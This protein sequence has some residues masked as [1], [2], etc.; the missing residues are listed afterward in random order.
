MFFLKG[1]EGGIEKEGGN[2]VF[3]ITVVLNCNVFIIVPESH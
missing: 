1:G 2:H 3:L